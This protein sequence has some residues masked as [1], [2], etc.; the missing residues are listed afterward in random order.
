[1]KSSEQDVAA[2]FDFDG[3]LYDGILYQGLFRHHREHNFNVGK[4][5]C[6]M[7][8]HMPI[9]LLSLA[10][11]F[12]K[13]LLYRMHGANL[14]WVLPIVLAAL[15]VHDREPTPQ[16]EPRA[17]LS[18]IPPLPKP[19]GEGEGAEEPPPRISVEN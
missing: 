13:E 5:Y 7:L 18:G 14:A 16:E 15:A 12:P 10:K 19:A 9:W 4:V 3:T 6:F 17:D 11:L 2:I 1:M 8:C